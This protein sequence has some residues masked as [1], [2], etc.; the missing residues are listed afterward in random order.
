MAFNSPLQPWI[1]FHLNFS[2]EFDISPSP[3]KPCVAAGKIINC[4]A[5]CYGDQ[6]IDDFGPRA[7]LFDPSTPTN[8]VNCGIWWAVSIADKWASKLPE[9]LI[10]S[11]TAILP[12]IGLDFPLL[13]FSIDNITSTECLASLHDYQH[14]NDPAAN[15]CSFDT[16]FGYKA[17]YEDSTIGNCIDALCTP[18]GSL[19]P[20]IGGIG[21]MQNQSTRQ[22]R[23]SD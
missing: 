23:I 15:L 18:T 14:P 19:D 6:S 11:A 17:L 8:L 2:L 3:L 5:I 16:I 20:D 21:V 4:S 12:P 22:Q 7:A 10:A 9:N 13:G 1:D